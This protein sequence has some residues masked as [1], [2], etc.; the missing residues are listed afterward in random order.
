MINNTP[1]KIMTHNIS[2]VKQLTKPTACD[3][4]IKASKV[5]KAQA[6]KRDNLAIRLLFIMDVDNRIFFGEFTWLDE[7]PVVDLPQPEQL[8]TLQSPWRHL[9]E[10]KMYWTG[11]HQ[12]CKSYIGDNCGFSFWQ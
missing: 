4:S 3:K 11:H 8:E 5:T 2:G 9:E 12:S 7:P 1:H 10:K 6:Q